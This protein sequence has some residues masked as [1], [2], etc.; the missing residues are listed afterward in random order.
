M[1]IKS[2]PNYPNAKHNDSFERGIEF[3]DFVCEKMLSELGIAFTNYQSRKFQFG[4]GENKQGIE[5]KLDDDTTRTG[6]LSIEVG[7]KSRI[8]LPTY[9]DSGILR[10]DNSW[11]YIQGN[12][13]IIY[14]FAKSILLGIYHNRKYK[15]DELPTL[16]RFLMPNEIAWKYAAKVLEFNGG[17]K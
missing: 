16:R 14:I 4:N 10:N 13:K 17:D 6:N 12:Y 7:E 11:L 9:T 15:I 2:A 8:N 3:Q 5:I 1:V